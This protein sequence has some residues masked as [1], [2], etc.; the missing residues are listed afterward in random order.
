MNLGAF[1][2]LIIIAIIFAIELKSKTP[3]L[4]ILISIGIC[5]VIL[6]V[7]IIRMREI[8]EVLMKL[9]GYIS[10][11]STYLLVLL[12]L[13]GI[14]YICEFAAGISKEAGFG[15][16]STQIELLGKLTMLVLS[17]P[18]LLKVLELVLDIL[19]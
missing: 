5:I 19:T 12:R 13:I 16:I 7:C 11:D 10:I 18:V 4:S 17:I 8:N 9:T 6:T 14:A 15:S 1:V 2:S 3:E